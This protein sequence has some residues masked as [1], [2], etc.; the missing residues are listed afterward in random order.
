ME[1]QSPSYRND[2]ECV[3]LNSHAELLSFDDLKEWALGR[4]LSVDGLE[5]AESPW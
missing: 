5:R 2:L 1:I 4:K 3:S